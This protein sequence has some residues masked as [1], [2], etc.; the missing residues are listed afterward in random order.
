MIQTTIIWEEMISLIMMVNYRFPGSLA[1]AIFVFDIS[2]TVFPVAFTWRR[3]V[4]GQTELMD[5]GVFSISLKL[6]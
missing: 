3:K 4:P 2:R 6:E 1:K 5:G